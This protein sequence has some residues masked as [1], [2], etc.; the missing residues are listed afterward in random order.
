M[1][2]PKSSSSTDFTLEFTKGI[3]TRLE[4]H[5]NGGKKAVTDS[6]LLFLTI[7]AIAKRNGVGRID[8]VCSTP[9][10]CDLLK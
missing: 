1:L 6:V 4:F 7:N 9:G 8:I 2:T 10:A 5:E 3:P